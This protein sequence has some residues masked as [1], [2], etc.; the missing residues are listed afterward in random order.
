MSQ[1]D[2]SRAIMEAAYKAH[3]AGRLDDAEYRRLRRARIFRPRKWRE[4]CELVREEAVLAGVVMEDGTFGID[5]DSLLAFI[6]RLIPLLL[7]LID[8]F[9]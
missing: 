3:E 8:L 9:S 6:E 4:C 5:W 7:Q 2:E 1:F